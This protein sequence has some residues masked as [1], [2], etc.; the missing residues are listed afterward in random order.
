[1]A[2]RGLYSDAFTKRQ[3][4]DDED[5]DITPMIDVTFLLLIFFMVTS[6]MQQEAQL[7]V[8]PARHG[9]GVSVDTA[10]MI[11]IANKDDQPAI[12]LGDGMV[13]DPVDVAQIGPYV[14]AEVREGK[15]IVIIKA[16]RELPS[17]FVED[18]A[19]TANEVPGISKFYVGIQD[20]PE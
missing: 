19:R 9:E 7:Q 18:V 5:L 14:D 4:P 8:P 15:Q 20:K 16:D 3:E 11:T 17:G 13:G 10:I 12:Y 2:K 1:M 6:T